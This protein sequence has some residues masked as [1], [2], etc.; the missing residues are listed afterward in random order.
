MTWSLALEPLLPVWLIVAAGPG[1]PYMRPMMTTLNGLR[2]P[3][4][5]DFASVSDHARLPW[6]FFGRLT[7]D[8]RLVG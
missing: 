3:R 5:E 7:A 4:T 2:T 8:G 1:K 6:R